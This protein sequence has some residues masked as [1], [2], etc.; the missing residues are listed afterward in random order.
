MSQSTG[1]SMLKVRV[2]EDH[3]DNSYLNP[4]CSN[5]R[6]RKRCRGI[7][8]D[9]VMETGFNLFVVPALPDHPGPIEAYKVSL[10]GA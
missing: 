5:N 6:K 7:S 3:P 10:V 4:G 1:R 2:C 9:L 8:L